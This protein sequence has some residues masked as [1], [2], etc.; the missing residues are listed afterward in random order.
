MHV[1]SLNFDRAD[2]CNAMI[3]LSKPRY[4]LQQAAITLAIGPVTDS[5]T[6]YYAPQ[7]DILISPAPCSCDRYLT[8]IIIDLRKLSDKPPMNA[9]DG[10]I[11]DQLYLVE[12]RLV[13][14][15]NPSN[16]AHHSPSCQ[17]LIRPPFIAA[18]IYIYSCL[19]DFPLQAPLFD[20]FVA[21]LSGA[22]FEDPAQA[23][24]RSGYSML[25]WV[26]AMGSMAA[27][28]RADRCRF[29]AELEG[30]SGALDVRTFENFENTLRRI[31]WN[32]RSADA[33]KSVWGDIL[34]VRQG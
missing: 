30:I 12:R 14:R 17:S 31:V 18:V 11:T 16:K 1:L 34:E 5:M 23:W 26:L 6:T 8:E 28:G 13:T 3:S 2:V 32:G 9:L 25:H 4:N 19:R 7:S 10:S 29:I 24:E 20:A 27:S 21:R 33:L 15:L 22:L